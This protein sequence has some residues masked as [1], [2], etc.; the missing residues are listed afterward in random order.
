MVW[1]HYY[2]ANA[3]LRAL[4]AIIIVVIAGVGL[5]FLSHQ[6]EAVG[7]PSVV[8]EW[9]G[10][11]NWP[12]KA[13]HTHLLPDGTVMVWPSSSSEHTIYIWNPVTNV[14]EPGPLSGFNLF[15]A[16]HALTSDGKLFV[17]G[18][19]VSRNVGIKTASVFDP[20]TNSWS[21]LPDMN[22]GRWYPNVTPLS[23]GD[24]LVVAGTVKNNVTNQL[25]QIWDVSEQKWKN[26]TG[27]KL[28]IPSYSFMF[29]TPDGR[30]FNAGPLQGSRFLSLGG[31]GK[32]S[33]AI[34]SNFGKRQNG[35]AVMYEPGKIL[36]LAGTKNSDKKPTNTAETIDL[37]AA[38]PKWKKTGSMSTIR[39]HANSTLLPTGEVLVTGGSKGIG[40]D[41][42][43]PVYL[44]E[45]WNPA[46]GAWTQLSSNS[47][48]RGYHSTALLLPDA[49]VLVAGGEKSGTSMEIFSPP[50]LFKGPRPTITSAPAQVGYGQSFFVETPDAATI[51]KVRWI[52]L[53]SVTHSFNQSQLIDTLDFTKQTTGLQ[54]TASSNANV[55]TPGYYMLFILSDAGVPSVS[56][57]MQ[58][59][60]IEFNIPAAGTFKATAVPP[61]DSDM[62]AD[63]EQGDHEV[64]EEN[65]VER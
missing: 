20:A 17:A 53:G 55:I 23:N 2:M 57:I 63:H 8:G 19:H 26:L 25:P 24:L 36:L 12:V 48:Y 59:G 43:A 18:G 65:L 51:S 28:D 4:A 14:I 16:G 6:A 38:S 7:D 41:E 30:A 9:S 64:E 27:A 50:Y 42:T 62:H 39:R 13:T 15:C 1:P 22:N 58:L 10:V 54:V 5:Y 47:T 35:T 49:R 11:S 32:W 40:D 44:A 29:A 37:N 34:N 61:V 33:K 52:K 21:Q 46:T 45:V 31:T 60:D 3:K 56:R